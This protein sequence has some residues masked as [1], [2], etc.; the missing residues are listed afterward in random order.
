MASKSANKIGPITGSGLLRRIFPFLQWAPSVTPTT[1][2]ADFI[3]G[4]VGAIIVLPQGIAFAAIA[5]LPPEYGLY[6]AMVTPI[7][8]ALFSSSLHS[9]SGPTT[10]ISIVVFSTV[11]NFATPG[12]PEFIQLALTLTLLAGIFQLVAGAAGLGAVVNFVSLN[13]VVGFTAGTAVLIAEGQIKNILG[14]EIPQSDSFLQTLA[15]LKS[16]IPDTNP[17]ALAIGL[18]T[19]GTMMT[20]SRFAPKLPNLLI[21]LIAGA[22]FSFLTDAA[23][24]GVAHLAALPGHLPPISHPDVS[25]TLIKKLAPE[26]LAVALL[27]LISTVSISQSVAMRSGQLID[28]NQEFI[29]QGVSNI[30]GSFFSAYAGSGS[31][32]RSG[33]NYDA[34]AKTPMSGIFAALLLMVIVLAI[35]PLMIYLP[36]P[37]IGAAI[38]LVAYNL[39]D[40]RYIRK[41][42]RVSRREAAILTV[43]FV[44]TLVFELEFAIYFGVL[45]S[46]TLFL[47]RTSTPDIVAV[48]PIGNTSGKRRMGEAPDRAPI[49]CPQIKLIRIDMSIYFGSVNHIEGRLRKITDKEGYRHILVLG[50]GVNFI[51]MSGAEM[52][53]RM[54]ARLRALGGGLYFCGVKPHVCEYLKKSGYA[55]EFG[56]DNLFFKKSEAIAEVVERINH[57]ICAACRARVFLECESLPNDFETEQ[58][59]AAS[60]S[61]AEREPAVAMAGPQG[62]KGDGHAPDR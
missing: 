62:A 4:I 52:L 23:S 44:S 43:T 29:G 32:T 21:G 49:E 41:V 53:V 19:M 34:G 50:A 17:Y 57:R 24:H 59:A 48:A 16:G 42:I 2:K 6:T 45:L 60:P 5:G 12:S 47:M 56:A 33:V 27:G 22:L 10:A 36:I 30:V 11:G 46:L 15:D 8:A 7:V 39:I 35:A 25:L 1:L 18:V 58:S 37:A 3:A 20:V 13:V 40:F 61:A 26:A 31:F 55:E 54:A 14:I 38:L 9:I 51:D 28:S